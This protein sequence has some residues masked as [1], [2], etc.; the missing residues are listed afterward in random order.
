MVRFIKGL[1]KGVLFRPLGVTYGKSSYILRPC[2]LHGASRI[3]LGNDTVIMS[4]GYLSAIEEREGHRYAPKIRIGDDVYIG[5]DV[6]LTA[7]DEISIGDGCVLS[8]QVYI[9]DLSH[10][11]QPDRGPIMKQPLESKGPVRIGPRCFLGYRAAIMPGVTLGEHCVVGANSVVTRSFPP[12]SMVAGS[13]ARLIK[14][15]REHDAA[16]VSIGEQGLDE[17]SQRSHV[18]PTV[19]S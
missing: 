6:Y 11:L 1:V 9:T 14:T 15:Y 5:R 17:H 19:K 16:W 10:G 13:P 2:V 18:P 12:F 3:R 8:E 7:M 4:R